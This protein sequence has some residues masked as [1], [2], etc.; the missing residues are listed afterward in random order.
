MPTGLDFIYVHNIFEIMYVHNN[1]EPEDINNIISQIS[2]VISGA[3]KMNA[4]KWN[5]N[6]NQLINQ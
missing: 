1:L 5:F 2:N 6:S 4:T 3:E